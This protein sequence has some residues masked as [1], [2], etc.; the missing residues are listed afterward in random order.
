MQCES[1]RR[2]FSAT[3]YLHYK[4]RDTAGWLSE[5]YLR[6]GCSGVDSGDGTGDFVGVCLVFGVVECCQQQGLMGVIVHSGGCLKL[7]SDW[8]AF[9]QTLENACIVL[10]LLYAF[11]LSRC[12]G[13]CGAEPIER[14]GKP[15]LFLWN[16][17]D[18]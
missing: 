14:P 8:A 18:E 15:N 6:H 1:R 13:F 16:G 17:N 5:S 12:K 2:W 9:M 7:Q 11:P 10:I 3:I 4:L